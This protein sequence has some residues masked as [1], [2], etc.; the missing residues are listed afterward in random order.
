MFAFKQL[1]KRE[2]QLGFRSGGDW[3]SSLTF[4]VLPP[5]L[6][7]LGAGGGANIG[8]GPSLSM[9][10]LTTMLAMIAGIDRMFHADWQSGYLDY[11]RL[12]P[13]SIL[14]LVWAKIAAFALYL[15]VPMVV[16]GPFVFR[17]IYVNAISPIA[18]YGLA[19]VMIAFGIAMA[20]FGAMISALVTAARGSSALMFVLLLPLAVPV[21]IFAIAASQ[22]MIESADWYPPFAALVA[23]AIA[24]TTLCPVIV[25]YCIKHLDE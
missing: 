7:A 23:I 15:V 5:F 12:Q 16:M 22:A 17:L 10:F 24:A 8:L 4:F 13:F 25:G 3:G 2:L 18:F 9:L 1:F 20:M 11:V 6:F 19:S 14:T 21:L